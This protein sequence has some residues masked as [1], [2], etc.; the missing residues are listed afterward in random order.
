MTSSSEQQLRS[1]IALL[2]RCNRKQYELV[3]MLEYVLGLA[4][5]AVRDLGS[6]DPR[7]NE[8]RAALDRVPVSA[9]RFRY[10]WQE[11]G[12]DLSSTRRARGSTS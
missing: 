8:F 10:G 9:L 1:D 5:A 3:R 7:I 6:Q 12:L 11:Q 4:E 2:R